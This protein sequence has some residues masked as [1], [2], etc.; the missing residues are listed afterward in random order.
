MRF[1]VLRAVKMRIMVFC[2]VMPCRNLVSGDSQGVIS[3]V[4]HIHFS[5]GKCNQLYILSW[6][7]SLREQ[8]ARNLMFS[9]CGYFF[10]HIQTEVAKMWL[11][12]SPFVCLSTC[13]NLKI[14]RWIF[15]RNDCKLEKIAF[16]GHNVT[17][18]KYS[19][20]GCCRLFQISHKT[21]E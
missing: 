6:N 20:N 11:S 16:L 12:A 9:H 19:S 2:V 10:N 17:K 13:N 3:R 4:L 21:C 7:Y 14:T 8:K 5:K 18:R 15:V 1:E